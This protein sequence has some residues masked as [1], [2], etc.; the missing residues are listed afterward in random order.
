MLR[1]VCI[2]WLLITS[3]LCEKRTCSNDDHECGQ[4]DRYSFDQPGD[5]NLRRHFPDLKAIANGDYQFPTDFFTAFC[6]VMDNKHGD[7]GFSGSWISSETFIKRLCSGKAAAVLN[8]LVPCANDKRVR[9][10]LMRSISNM[11]NLPEPTS[12]L[13]VEQ[14][15]KAV[16]RFLKTTLTKFLKIIQSSCDAE[17]F[18]EMMKL[19][20]DILKNSE[21]YDL[22]LE[23]ACLTDVEAELE[24]RFQ[25]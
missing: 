23:G 10:N 18:Q 15:Q 11:S 2:Q 9:N 8:K 14:A 25:Y 1:S 12:D 16:C 6:E 7:A 20:T 22:P 21:D 13:S 19:V 24:K 17:G 3:V 5:L 4:N